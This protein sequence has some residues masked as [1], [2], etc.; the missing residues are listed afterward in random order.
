MRNEKAA[1]SALVVGTAEEMVEVCS[2]R[3]MNRNRVKMLI[4]VLET[5]ESSTATGVMVLVELDV[6]PAEAMDEAIVAKAEVEV[7]TEAEILLKSVLKCV[8]K[9][10]NQ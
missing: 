5:A 1:V 4:R 9:K 10:S 8:P 7:V 3:G 2:G 6:G